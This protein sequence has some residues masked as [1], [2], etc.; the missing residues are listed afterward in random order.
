MAQ[1]TLLLW[2]GEEGVQLLRHA[3]DG[4]HVGVRDDGVGGGTAL[5]GSVSRQVL[6]VSGM[7]TM[8]EIQSVEVREEGG[9]VIRE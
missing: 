7:A 2:L 1:L 3:G 9:Q 8:S 5:L 4:D 6:R